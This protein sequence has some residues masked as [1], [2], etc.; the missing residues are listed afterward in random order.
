MS[1]PQFFL[2]YTVSWLIWKLILGP[3]LGWFFSF[4]ADWR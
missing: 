4:I 3:L 2:Y 1:F